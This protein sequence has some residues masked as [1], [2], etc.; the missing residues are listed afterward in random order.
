MV[1]ALLKLGCRSFLKLY[2]LNYYDN[3]RSRPYVWYILYASILLNYCIPYIQYHYMIQ[4]PFLHIYCRR[5]R[6]AKNLKFWS[7]SCKKGWKRRTRDSSKWSRRQ[8]QTRTGCWKPTSTNLRYIRQNDVFITLN[9]SIHGFK[10]L[11]FHSFD[12]LC[13]FEKPW[14]YK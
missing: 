13:S 4:F 14:C 8:N 11:Y 9:Y 7:S 1:L 12:S 2:L 5:N 10:L 6:S 3:Y